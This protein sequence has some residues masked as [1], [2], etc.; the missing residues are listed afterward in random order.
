MRDPI[1]NVLQGFPRKAQRRALEQRVVNRVAATARC[2]SRARRYDG[3]KQGKCSGD[4]ANPDPK[5]PSIIVRIPRIHH[6]SMIA[7]RRRGNGI[8]AS[9]CTSA[10]ALRREVIACSLPSGFLLLLSA[11]P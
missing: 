1:P 9:R 8:R 11:S 6:R 2:M 10:M 3:R 5:A 4:R 7:R